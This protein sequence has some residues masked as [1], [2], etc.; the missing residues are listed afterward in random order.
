MVENYLLLD[1]APGKKIEVAKELLKCH[2]I[3]DL[4]LLLG[5]HD[6]I[7]ETSVPSTQFIKDIR[8]NHKKILRNA[9][10]TANFFV[11]DG[12]SKAA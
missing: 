8:F 4:H 10:I 3:T 11:D 9:R 12:L 7:V 1:T 6:I 5:E 2:N